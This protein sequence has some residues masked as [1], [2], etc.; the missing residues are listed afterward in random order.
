[1]VWASDPAGPPAGDLDRPP[2]RA[3]LG[4]LALDT[5]EPPPADGPLTAEA[6]T[7]LDIVGAWLDAH[8]GE[9]RVLHVEGEWSSALPRIPVVEEEEDDDDLRLVVTPPG[10]APAHEGGAEAVPA[11]A[12]QPLVAA[13]A[14]G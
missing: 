14:A 11:G 13:G 2:R 3:T 9:V 10:E 8:A 7:E 12:G 4:D 5:A 1:V 6:A